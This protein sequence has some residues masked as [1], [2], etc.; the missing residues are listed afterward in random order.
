MKK[1]I[2]TMTALGLLNLAG[3]ALASN[4][5]TYIGFM[6][7]ANFMHAKGSDPKL[8]EGT[9]V[10]YNT[11]TAKTLSEFGIFVGWSFHSQYRWLSAFHRN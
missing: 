8:Q 3:S 7:G 11:N 10:T 4:V 2:F 6:A 5:S 1:I 9:V